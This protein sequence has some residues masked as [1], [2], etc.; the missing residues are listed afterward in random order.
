MDFGNKKKCCAIVN[1]KFCFSP[2]YLLTCKAKNLGTTITYPLYS[3]APSVWNLSILLS[4][5]LEKSFCIAFVAFGK[6]SSIVFTFVAI[7]SMFYHLR[8]RFGCFS[9]SIAILISFPME[10]GYQQK[11]EGL[12]MYGF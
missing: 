2:D 6:N 10:G 11:L 12:A 4:S 7:L 3:G 5:T 1:S 8:G 9:T